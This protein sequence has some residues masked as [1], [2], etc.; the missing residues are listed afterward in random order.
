MRGF[1]E[2]QSAFFTDTQTPEASVM[3]R[4]VFNLFEKWGLRTAEM[5]T[6]LGSPAERTFH[7]WR[8]GQVAG[9]PHDTVYRLACLLGIH[10]ALR[11]MFSAP[12][13]GYEWVKKPNQAFGGKSALDKMLQGAPTDLAELRAYLDAER[14]GW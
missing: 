14:A 1:S 8:S 2:V 11:Y 6:L 10:K 4:A 9:V 12:E 13:R 3:L 7:R 5:R